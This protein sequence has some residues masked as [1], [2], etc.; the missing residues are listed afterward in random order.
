MREHDIPARLV[1][2]DDISLWPCLVQMLPLS[3]INDVGD[4]V[5]NGLKGEVEQ[6][7]KYRAAGAAIGGFV[8]FLIGTGTGIVGGPFGATAGVT[9]FSLVGVGW[10]ISAGPD[11][12]ALLRRKRRSE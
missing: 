12:A 8:G 1:S 3:V 11:V 5:Q 10:G 6:K 4:R 9:I 7:M 2:Y